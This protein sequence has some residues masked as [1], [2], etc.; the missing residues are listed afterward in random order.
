ML[1]NKWKHRLIELK[2]KKEELEQQREIYVEKRA[3]AKRELRYTE[4]AQRILREVAKLT[5]DQ[6]QYRITELVTLAM[7][8]VFNEPYEL[9]LEVVLRRGKTEIDLYFEHDGKRID[10]E[11]SSSGGVVDVAAFALQISLWSL[12]KSKTRAILI[13]DEPLKWLKGQDYPEKGAAVIQE[14]AHKLGIQVITVSH[15]TEQIE[16]ADRVFKAEMN[17]GISNISIRTS[18]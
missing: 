8:A 6:L 11:H 10:I 5:Q 2:A 1:V 9:K 16:S 13:L 3:I 15:S 12:Q 17:E 4:Q 14:I 7:S 18:P